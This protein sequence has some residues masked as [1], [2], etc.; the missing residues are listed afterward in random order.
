[1]VDST[2]CNTASR[3]LTFVQIL[4]TAVLLTT[5]VMVCA[6]WF[7]SH[8]QTGTREEA[9][10]ASNK[11]INAVEETSAVREKAAEYHTHRVPPRALIPLACLPVGKSAVKGTV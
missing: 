5:T 9:A 11:T 10:A 6:K 8:D 2:L 1:M 4:V 3:H 7:V